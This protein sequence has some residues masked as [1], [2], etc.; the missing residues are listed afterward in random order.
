MDQSAA[1][2]SRRSGRTRKE[3]QIRCDQCYLTLPSNEYA[4][5]LSQHHASAASTTPAQVPGPSN[6]PPLRQKRMVSRDRTKQTPAAPT[7][8]RKKGDVGAGLTNEIV[9]IISEVLDD[10]DIPSDGTPVALSGASI[11]AVHCD[12][13]GKNRLPAQS[14][15][16]K[17]CHVVISSQ[18][19]LLKHMMRHKINDVNSRKKFDPH[20]LMLDMKACSILQEILKETAGEGRKDFVREVLASV[21][22]MPEEWKNFIQSLCEPMLMSFAKPTSLMPSQQYED[23]LKALDRY[24]N[25][26]PLIASLVTDFSQFASPHGEVVP[27]IV[28]TRLCFK[29]LDVILQFEF[30]AMKAGKNTSE[31][32]PQEINRED[33]EIH[34]RKFFQMYY[35]KGVKS[36]SSRMLARCACI[37]INFIDSNCEI[38]SINLIIDNTSWEEDANG[39]VKVK[40]K[41]TV[42]DFFYS[43]EKIIQSFLISGKTVNTNNVVDVLL[44]KNILLEPWYILSNAFEE[45]E[46]LIFLS[47]I[48]SKLVKLSI[49][50]ENRKVRGEV[51]NKEQYAL[52]T[53]LKRN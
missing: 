9:P 39:T 7:R 18:S 13:S 32:Q 40:L 2:P 53:D 26:E 28:L 31:V 35:M 49:K 33:F 6:E 30:E 10:P 41:E 25:N 43:V 37:R 29:L 21:S 52:R 8:R 3:T 16:C 24:L 20:E 51:G 46:S 36:G 1:G 14:T 27:R 5:H 48:I 15:Q 23:Q 42:V 34:L 11:E 44:E 50:L 45:E 38:D 19:L 17:I 4:A 47:D 12:Q 22:Q